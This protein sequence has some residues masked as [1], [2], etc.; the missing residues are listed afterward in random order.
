MNTYYI[1]EEGEPEENK[2]FLELE[3]NKIPYRFKIKPNE[4][5]YFLIVKSR[6]DEVFIERNK[7]DESKEKNRP[8]GAPR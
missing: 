4:M 2:G 5:F 6:G 3:V 8:G 7:E 1:S